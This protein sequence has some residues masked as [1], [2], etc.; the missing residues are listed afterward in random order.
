MLGV[1]ARRAPAP[2]DAGMIPRPICGQCDGR[3]GLDALR[4]D[5]RCRGGTWFAYVRQS[6]A[7]CGVEYMAIF[8][9]DPAAAAGWTFVKTRV[10]SD[11]KGHLIKRPRRTCGGHACGEQACGEQAAMPAA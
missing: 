5:V 9:R 11:E 1:T 4:T 3:L 2:P 10:V 8:R 6:C 7:F